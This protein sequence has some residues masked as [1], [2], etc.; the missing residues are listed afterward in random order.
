MKRGQVQVRVLGHP[1]DGQALIGQL[2]SAGF[3][4][5]DYQKRNTA[6]LRRNE[7]GT[8]RAYLAVKIDRPDGPLERARLLLARIEAVCGRYRT[9]LAEVADLLANPDVTD[10]DFD[11]EWGEG[12]AAEAR[13]ILDAITAGRPT[14]LQQR[15]AES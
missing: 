12:L 6:R 2:L 5:P 8:A 3:L 1:D 14:P 11:A 4:G 10:E 9:E 15:R 7:D 13:R